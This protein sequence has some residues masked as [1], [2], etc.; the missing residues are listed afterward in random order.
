MASD[1]SNV[2]SIT[3]SGTP[4][5]HYARAIEEARAVREHRSEIQTFDRGR[6]CVKC[7]SIGA[8]VEFV[9]FIKDMGELLY[10]RSPAPDAPAS[11][12]FVVNQQHLR[13]TCGE[14]GFAWPEATL[15]ARVDEAM[16]G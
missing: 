11:D 13:R 7:G 3:F 16:D 12:S 15:D 1:T 4:P 6:A 2:G 5:V 8:R 10:L 14:C 9:G